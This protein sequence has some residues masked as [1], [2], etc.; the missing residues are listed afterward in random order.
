MD[1]RRLIRVKSHERALFLGFTDMTSATQAFFN[2]LSTS[3]LAALIRDGADRSIFDCRSKLGQPGWGRRAFEGGHISGAQFLDLDHDLALPPSDAGRHPLPSLARWLSIVRRFGVENT[4]QVILYDDAGGA[5]AGRAWWMF[6]WLG[7]EAVAVL[8]GGLNA[9]QSDL[10]TS[11]HP[12]PEPSEF[13]SKPALTKLVST[14]DLVS[15]TGRTLLDARAQAR[16]DG[17]EEPIDPV[18]GHIPGAMCFPFPE[19]LDA[20]GL[21]KAPDLLKKRF[22]KLGDDPICYCGSGV[23]ACHNILA[24]HIAGLPEPTLYADSWS[25]WITDPNREVASR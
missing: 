6:R 11:T 24:M 2:I 16:F 14:T 13:Q 1:I 17:E 22:A 20:N 19:N 23:T 7:H 15:N 25:G 9:W 21:F 18:A 8:D 4:H 12:L 5:Y 3:D 10:D